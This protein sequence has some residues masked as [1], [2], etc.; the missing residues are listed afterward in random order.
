MNAPCSNLVSNG[1]G[2]NC[3]LVFDEAHNIGRTSFFFTIVS[4]NCISFS[5]TISHI[6]LT[7][8]IIIIITIIVIVIIIII[9]TTIIILYCYRHRQHRIIII[10]YSFNDVLVWLQIMCVSRHWVW[11]SASAL[12]KVQQEMSTDSLTSS[13]SKWHTMLHT[14]I[15]IYVSLSLSLRIFLIISLHL[16]LTI[17]NSLY[18]SVISVK[19][20][21]S[22]SLFLGLFSLLRYA[23]LISKLPL[24]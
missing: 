2:D 18:L 17:S 14:D 3:I 7:I 4:S 20:F 23:F 21:S 1:L 19:I 22:I 24:S 6:V 13:V 16:F 9:I 8:I 15:Y 5:I 10:P 12:L 11:D